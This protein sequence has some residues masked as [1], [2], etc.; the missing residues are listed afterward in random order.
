MENERKPKIW[1]YLYFRF[2]NIAAG[3]LVGTDRKVRVVV[4]GISY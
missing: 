1:H 2:M 3:M 4:T